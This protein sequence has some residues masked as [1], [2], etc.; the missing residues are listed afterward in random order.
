M[1]ASIVATLLVAFA[2]GLRHATDADHMAAVAALAS[3]APDVTCS[4][5]IGALWGLGHMATICAFGAVLITLRVRLSAAVEWTFELIVALVLVALGARTI[6]KC[7]TGRYHFHRH[8]HGPLA[9]WHLHFHPRHGTAEEHDAHALASSRARRLEQS[10]ALLV[11]MAHGF[12]GTAGLALLVLSTIPS[13][14]V[15]VA[16]LV[17]FGLGALV[18]MAAFGAIVSVPLARAAR[19]LPGPRRRQW[20]RCRRQGRS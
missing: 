8:Y 5:R 3:N 12:A 4:M 7:F 13:R 15:A 19:R 2:L 14:A 6:V 9:H 20:R 17:L 10:R 1:E 11:G 16:Y 18:G